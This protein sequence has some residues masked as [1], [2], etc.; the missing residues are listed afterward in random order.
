MTTL[1]T[2]L[3]CIMLLT[4]SACSIF[5][6]RAQKPG[7]SAEDLY[8][9][10]KASLD[11]G[12]FKE[13]IDKFE[14]LEARYPFGHYS[15]Q[16][17]LETAY[18]YYKFKEADSAIST[19]D[20][21]IKLYPRQEH[22]DY[23]YYLRGLASYNLSEGFLNRLFKVDPTQRDAA[24]ARQSFEYFAELVQRFPDSKY[25]PDAVQRMVYL[26]NALA[27]H[28]VHVA[29]YY[30]RRGAYL[31]SANRAKYVLVNYDRTP[32]VADAL[33]I[34]VKSY[35]KLGMNELADSAQK[36]LDLNY[37][38]YPNSTRHTPG[39]PNTPVPQPPRAPASAPNTPR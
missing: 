17:L 18:A 33:A 32:A 28:E 29:D 3:L 19:A 27:Q 8:K 6:T 37:P 9:E 12:A 13:A 25:A 2:T 38:D 21:F 31:A 24:R 39:A 20:R 15:Q 34:M 11:A 22:V 10:G 23:A 5:P 26:K 1:R 16:A 36:I 7:E 4:A 30:Y 14:T 35:R